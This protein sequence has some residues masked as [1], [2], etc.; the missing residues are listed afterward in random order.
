MPADF[1]SR[2]VVETIEISANIWVIYKTKKYIFCK[3]IKKVLTK[4]LV[5]KDY[6]KC[7]K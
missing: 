5:E 3:S 4:L 6:K 1:L 2:N 7:K